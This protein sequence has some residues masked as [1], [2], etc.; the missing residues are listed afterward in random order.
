M[1]LFLDKLRVF[2][3]TLLSYQRPH[4]VSPAGSAV[5]NHPRK[6]PPDQLVFNV[7]LQETGNLRKTDMK[8]GGLVF[9]KN[10]KILRE[11]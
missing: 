10:G 8:G 3:H 9:L 7:D 2:R 4:P 6:I 5:T 1:S 11:N